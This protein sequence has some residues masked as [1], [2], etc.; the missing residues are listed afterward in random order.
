MLPELHFSG[1]VYSPTPELRMIMINDAVVREGQAI[2][3]ELTLL[4]ITEAGVILRF[5]DTPHE[6]DLF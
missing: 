1:H 4:E 2:S 3:P 5:K 6:I